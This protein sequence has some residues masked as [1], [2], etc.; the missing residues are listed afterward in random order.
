ML[1]SS[2]II[3]IR[4][5]IADDLDLMRERLQ[6]MLSPME[7]L[8]IVGPLTNGTET[9]EALRSL[10]PDLAILDIETPGLTGLQVLSEIG[11]EG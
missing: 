8:E 11:K 7:K 4:K 6:Q 2:N 5:V 9:L 10:K 3:V 1:R